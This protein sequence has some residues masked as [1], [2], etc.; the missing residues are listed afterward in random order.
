MGVVFSLLTLLVGILRAMSALCHRFEGQVPGALATATAP[1]GVAA[2][3]A[4]IVGVIGA[5]IQAHRNRQAR[6]QR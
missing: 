6:L 1:A 2:T 3:D 4:E 5:A